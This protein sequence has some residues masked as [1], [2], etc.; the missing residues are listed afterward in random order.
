MSIELGSRYYQADC[1]DDVEGALLSPSTDLQTD[2]EY[3]LSPK[4]KLLGILSTIFTASVMLG[5]IVVSYQNSTV[6]SVSPTPPPVLKSAWSSKAEPFS[7]VDPT[8][9]GILSIDRPYNSKPGPVLSNLIAINSTSNNPETPL[10]T[11]TWYQN[12]ILGS[13][14]NDPE[15]KIFQ[16]P[17]I[18]DA[19]GFIPG[20][21]THPC[22]LQANDRMVMVS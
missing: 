21:R 7:V 8:T 19:A 22:H 6:S 12:L 1:S 14:N 17:Y 15:N 9:I 18:I 2:K 11:N 20:L 3:T 5:S 4:M 13:S 16:I 10:P